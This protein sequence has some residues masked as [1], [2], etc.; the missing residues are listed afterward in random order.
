MNCSTIR[1]GKRVKC[2][3]K[4]SYKQIVKNQFLNLIYVLERQIDDLGDGYTTELLHE[5]SRRNLT[6]PYFLK[7]AV[8]R[9]GFLPH[10]A[11]W[12]HR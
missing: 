7:C 8:A 3:A 10:F 1:F 11:G 4:C 12:A 9:H 5:S 2:S 6:R